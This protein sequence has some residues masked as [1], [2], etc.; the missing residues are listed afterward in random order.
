MH[1]ARQQML[2]MVDRKSF[3]PSALDNFLKYTKYIE[4]NAAFASKW[5]VGAF[6]GLYKCVPKNRGSP[7]SACNQCV[8]HKEAE[9]AFQCHSESGDCS[10][11]KIVTSDVTKGDPEDSWFVRSA[12]RKLSEESIATSDSLPLVV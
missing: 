7:Q 4:E 10:A 9:E 5:A 12:T 1:L 8:P 6:A 3:H 2:H 11:C